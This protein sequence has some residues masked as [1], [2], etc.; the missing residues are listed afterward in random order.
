LAVGAVIDPDLVRK[1]R[2]ALSVETQEGERYGET[3]EFSG[4]R[5]S[6]DQKLDVCLGVKSE[7][8]LDLFLSGL[9]P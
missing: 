3:K 4:N 7:K 9:R 5:I 1:E 6:D 2:L 8:F